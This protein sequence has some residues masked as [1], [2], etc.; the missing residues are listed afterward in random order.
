MITVRKQVTGC[1]LLV[2]GLQIRVTGKQHLP[3]I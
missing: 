1:Q 3:T 2:A